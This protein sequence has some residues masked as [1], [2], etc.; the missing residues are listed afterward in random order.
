[1]KKLLLTLF[2]FILVVSW[3]PRQVLHAQ[4]MGTAVT[5]QW[6]MVLER[7]DNTPLLNLAGYK[8]Y[9]SAE[10]GVYGV[11]PAVDI[12]NPGIA[13]Y[14]LEGVGE[15]LWYFVLTAYDADGLE[16]GYSNEVS[17]IIVGIPSPPKR[18]AAFR[19]VSP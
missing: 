3:E 4:V 14:V 16:S 15:G 7:E 9:Q 12:D 10:T 6:E 11:D 5:F 19:A 18:P 13:T 1:M 8:L 17:K 2:V